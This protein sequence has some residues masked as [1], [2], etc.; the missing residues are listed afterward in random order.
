MQPKR[1]PNGG[2]SFLPVLVGLAV[3][4]SCSRGDA[5]KHE[6]S[7]QALSERFESAAAPAT[8]LDVGEECTDFKGNEGCAS[9]LCLRIEPGDPEA[10]GGLR[11]RGFCSIA[12]DPGAGESECPD[13]PS[14]GL[15]WR[16][17][18]VWP[19]EKGWFCTF[20]KTWT[21]KKATRRG[22]VISAGGSSARVPMCAAQAPLQRAGAQ[23]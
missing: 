8:K 9:D 5:P 1:I 15:P 16:C 23:T 14:P 4:T 20:E 13:G 10:A 17:T 2:Q 6:R 7:T 22:Q 12:C 11:P 3:L 21:S 18:Q 19:S